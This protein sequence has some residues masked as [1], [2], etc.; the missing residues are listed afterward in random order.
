MNEIQMKLP[1]NWIPPTTQKRLFRGLLLLTLVVI[2]GLQVIDNHLKTGVA[3]SGIVSFELAGTQ[4]QAQKILASWGEKGRIY[5]GLSLGLDFLFLVAYS[6]LLALGCMLIL[7]TVLKRNKLL[8]LVG[9]Y[10]AWGQFVA[11]LLDSVENVSLI[12]VLVGS[13]LEAWPVLAH[14]CAIPKFAIVAV[15]IVYILLG[16]L[17]GLISGKA[18]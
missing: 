14:W 4:A 9:V 12:R 11:A 6:S 18:K 7:R 10:L 13:R 1:F 3:P 17:I 16:G 15:G 2:V 5:A 8:V